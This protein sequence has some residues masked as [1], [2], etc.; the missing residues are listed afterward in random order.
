MKERGRRPQPCEAPEHHSECPC[1]TCIEEAP[2]ACKNCSHITK[3]H[4]TPRA[5]AEFLGWDTKQLHSSDNKQW[6]SRPCH[7]EKD[8]DTPKRKEVIKRQVNGE[9]ITLQE[10]VM[11]FLGEESLD[12]SSPDQNQEPSCTV[13]ETQSPD[14]AREI[15]QLVVADD[16]ATLGEQYDYPAP[17]AVFEKDEGEGYYIF[18][19]SENRPSELIA[20]IHISQ[21]D[22]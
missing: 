13:V 12:S 10:H 14:E 8:L 17:Y 2:Q 9:E 19:T 1:T 20:D 18:N 15:L 16:H 21:G 5:V 3:D 4:F 11:Y 7:T 22:I 6:L